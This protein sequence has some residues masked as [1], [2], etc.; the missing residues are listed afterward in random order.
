MTRNPKIALLLWLVAAYGAGFVGVQ[1]VRRGFETGLYPALLKP[2]WTPPG[3]VFTV[4]WSVLYLLMGVAAW[5]VWRGESPRGAALGAW[6]AALLL[7]VAWPWA[8][9]GYGRLALAFGLCVALWL[10]VL[11]T[12]VLFAKRDRVASWLFVPYLAWVGFATILN[13]AILRMN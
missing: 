11:A 2:A 1:G 9:F 4:V 10:A 6:W 13:L 3:L 5:R 8:F 12:T 7:N